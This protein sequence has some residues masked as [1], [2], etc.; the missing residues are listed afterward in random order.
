MYI[1]E[2]CKGNQVT[3]RLLTPWQ[4]SPGGVKGLSKYPV[5]DPW[6][7]TWLLH[8]GYSGE[9]SIQCCFNW[10]ISLICNFII[11]TVTSQCARWRFQAPIK[12]KTSAMVFVM[13]IHRWPVDFPSQRA[14]NAGNCFVTTMFCNF[15]CR[16]YLTVSWMLEVS[17]TVTP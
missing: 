17:P 4:P 14:S 9:R 12:K 2:P 15:T 3:T 5:N 16:I 13:G 10:Y 7:V 1:S 6:R 8:P 11:I